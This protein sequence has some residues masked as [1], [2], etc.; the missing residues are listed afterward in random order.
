LPTCASCR[1]IHAAEHLLWASTTNIAL[2]YVLGMIPPFKVGRSFTITGFW[3]WWVVHLW[4]ER[5]FEVFAA[6]VSAYLEMGLGLVSRQLVERSV[7]LKLI[8]ILLGGIIS[9]EHHI[10]WVGGPGMWVP[11]GSMFSFIEVLPRVLLILDAMENHDLIQRQHQ[12]RLRARLHL[13]AWIGILELRRGRR[14]RRRHAQCA[15]RQLL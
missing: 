13:C 12:F 9:T 11:M 10:Y 5:S 14:V 2:L 1:R 6:A 3:R 7:Y 15:A 4:V 8:L